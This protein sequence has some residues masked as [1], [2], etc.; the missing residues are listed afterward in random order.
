M[1]VE[2]LDRSKISQPEKLLVLKPHR[3]KPVGA[4]AAKKFKPGETYEQ[5]GIE[6]VEV[7][8]R[9]LA[10]RDLKAEVPENE[11]RIAPVKGKER[12]KPAYELLAEQNAQIISLLT[13]LLKKK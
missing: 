7:V 1:A 6:K 4:L 13:E 8:I 10:T 11:K 12:F 9:G 5:S 3:A 2:V